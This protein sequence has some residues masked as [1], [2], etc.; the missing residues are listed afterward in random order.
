MLHEKVAKVK[1]FLQ[2]CK[3]SSQHAKFYYSSTLSPIFRCFIVLSPFTTSSPSRTL[4]LGNSTYNDGMKFILCNVYIYTCTYALCSH[5]DIKSPFQLQKHERWKR[6]HYLKY[7][8]FLISLYMWMLQRWAISTC[9]LQLHNQYALINNIL[10]FF[11]YILLK[12]A[13]LHKCLKVWI[14]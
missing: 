10:S 6:N 7:W 14:K 2:P 11:K 9:M 4:K 3:P 12:S 13:P 8:W 5:I 1:H